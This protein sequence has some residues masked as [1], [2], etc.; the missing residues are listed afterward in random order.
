MIV[1]SNARETNKKVFV[2][3]SQQRKSLQQLP[4]KESL[5]DSFPIKKVFVEEAISL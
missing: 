5:S 2:T 3:A 1:V 4:N